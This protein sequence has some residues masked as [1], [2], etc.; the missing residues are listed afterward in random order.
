MV[1]EKGN[2]K[3]DAMT[4]RQRKIERHRRQVAS[5]AA[6]KVG[7]AWGRASQGTGRR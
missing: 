4:R 2:V 3:E 1:Q 7:A 5:K 6:L